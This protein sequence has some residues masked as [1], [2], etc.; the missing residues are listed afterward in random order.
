MTPYLDLLA[1]C[2]TGMIYRDP[3][4]DPWNGVVRDADGRVVDFKTAGSAPGSFTFEAGV[5]RAVARERGQDWPATAHTMIGLKRLEAVRDLAYLCLRDGVPGDFIECGVWRGGAAIMM[6]GVLNEYAGSF[7]GK[8]RH[9][10]LADS[11]E[12]LPPPD[13][14]HEADKNSW[15]HV[16]P[17]LAVSQEEVQANIE[18]YGLMSTRV[19]FLK[20]WFKDTLPS[21]DTPIA[22]A[23]FDGDMYGSTMDCFMHLYERI[24]PGGYIIVD[25]FNSVRGCQQATNDF[26]KAFQITTPIKPID[27]Y[28]VYWK[29]AA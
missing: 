18:G 25:D 22:L 12:G 14:K 2:L 20:G 3:P 16:V 8:H 19:K 9:V 13:P 15:H 6:L 26:R 11:F 5:Y 1:K 7:P 17:S 24:V 21:V 28:G 4:M 29:K 23:R 27:D 10:W